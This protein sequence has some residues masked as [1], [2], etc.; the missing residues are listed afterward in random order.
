MIRILKTGKIWGSKFID[1]PLKHCGKY[2][3]NWKWYIDYY[4]SLPSFLLKGLPLAIFGYPWNFESSI[5]W[6]RMS[7]RLQP[8]AFAAILTSFGGI[9]QLLFPNSKIL[10]L[11]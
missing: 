5:I 7:Q 6:L 4:W 2:S 10:W 11:Y 1:I 8:V 3:R 9:M